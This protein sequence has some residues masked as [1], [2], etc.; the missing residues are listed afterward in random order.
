MGGGTLGWHEYVNQVSFLNLFFKFI[1]R[2]RGREGEREG[3]KHQ[4]ARDISIGCLSHTPYWGSGP[5][6]RHVPCLDIEPSTFQF[7]GQHSVH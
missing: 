4:C 1:F 2:E 6:P 5:Q 7:E 3:E